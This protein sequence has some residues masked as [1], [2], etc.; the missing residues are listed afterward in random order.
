MADS[1]VIDTL[2]DSLG[3]ATKNADALKKALSGVPLEKVRKTFES[4]AK[5]AG[6]STEQIS[7]FTDA[8]KEMIEALASPTLMVEHLGDAVDNLT[9]SFSKAGPEIV[10]AL[11]YSGNSVQEFGKKMVGAL[12]L[13]QVLKDTSVFDSIGG[14]AQKNQVQLAGM[15]KELAHTMHISSEMAT[16]ILTSADANRNFERSYFNLAAETGHFSQAIEGA[17]E[18]FQNTERTAL[19]WAQTVTD[20]AAASA[21][22]AG[23][24]GKLYAQLQTIPGAFQEM[25][26]S[27]TVGSKELT[28]LDASLK[29]AAGSGQDAGEI[30]GFMKEQVS[31]LG[32]STKDAITEVAELSIV[33]DKLNLP[34]KD[35]QGYVRASSSALREF[36][37]NAQGNLKIVSELAPALQRVGVSNQMVGEISKYVIDGIAGMTTAQKAFISAQTGGPGGL[38]GAAQIDLLLE[39]GKTEEVFG[40]IKQNLNQQFGGK[41]VTRKEAAGSEEA[42]GQFQKQIMFLTGPAGGGI[43]KDEK[44]AAKLLEAFSTGLSDIPNELK[45]P[46]MAANTI[47]SQGTKLQER[48][49]SYLASMDAKMKDASAT[50]QVASSEF[51]RKLGGSE[52]KGMEALQMNLNDRLKAQ[53]G[54]DPLLG[55]G[56]KRGLDY[57]SDVDRQIS[58]GGK[59]LKAATAPAREKIS[60]LEGVV[61]DSLTP[62]GLKHLFEKPAGRPNDNGHLFNNS[63]GRPNVAGE[64]AEGVR[65]S[66]ASKTETENSKGEKVIVIRQEITTVCEHCHKKHVETTSRKVS[67]E[68]IKANEKQNGEGAH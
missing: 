27:V 56:E 3:L 31:E 13:P 18:K 21:M 65:T 8:I 17:G 63:S 44:T 67:G 53:K 5:T 52:S 38:R 37:N 28:L 42:A 16:N 1:D 9:E 51:V 34:F 20:T 2:V 33:S 46:Q 30:M 10:N 4:F 6:L 23:E 60:Q 62:E 12:V 15:A 25:S 64:T 22:S 49:N 39:Q 61:K 47:L 55:K 58:E 43:A 48:A 26:T 35:L 59:D 45:N 57:G 19:G 36:G 32:G 14:S 11:G 29:V 41:F 66:K 54:R 7:K 24:V 50:S 40:K 68:M